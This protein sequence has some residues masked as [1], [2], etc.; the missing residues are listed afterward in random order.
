MKIFTAENIRKIDSQTM[1]LEPI[2][3][4]DLMERA[5]M[6]LALY[7]LERY[8]RS[9]LLTVFSG[10]GN[11]GG[12]GLA[13]SRIMIEK[14]YTV[15]TFFAASG[16]KP[17]RE[18]SGN[19]ERLKAMPGNRVH[20]IE[21]ESDFPEI[22]DRSVIIDALFGTGL[23]RPLKGVAA[24]LVTKIN[25]SGADIISVDIPS[26]LYSEDNSVNSGA[27]VRAT[28][29]LTLQFPKISFMFAENSQFTGRVEII[30]IGLHPMAISNT[31]SYF[32]FY[33]DGGC[34]KA[35]QG[36]GTV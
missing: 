5:A 25:D 24:Q 8:D 22:D 30:P 4:I 33:P 18:T 11:N 21:E 19:L 36:Q 35:F 28:V 1:E 26:G 32:P 6:R 16:A 29:T 9:N 10:P 12:D 27:V 34:N 15:N 14:G 20:M 7:I 17:S 2:S 23:N 3:S 31:S 13:L